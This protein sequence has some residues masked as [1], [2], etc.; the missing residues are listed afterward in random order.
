[1]RP[2]PLGPT[3]ELPMGPRSAALGGGAACYLPPLGPS[4]ELPMGQRNAALG[5]GSACELRHWGHR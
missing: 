2:L 3:A 5:G 1:M 4:A